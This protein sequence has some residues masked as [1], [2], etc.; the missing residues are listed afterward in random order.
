M[1]RFGEARDHADLAV[2]YVPASAHQMLATIGVATQQF[3]EAL[4][5]A[6]LAAAADP[7]LPLPTYVRG[8]I[9]YA[10][11]R[12][13]DA[14]PLFAA[15]HAAWSGRTIQVP[16]VRFY[17]GDTL[18]RFERYGEAERVFREELGLFPSS[19]RTRGALAMLYAATGREADVERAIDEMLTVSPGPATY[20]R[21]AELWQMFGRPDRAAAVR[22]ERRTRFGR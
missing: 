6:D 11:E 18:A 21:A 4:R 5:Q 2:P 22:N 16:D 20:D 3:D 17:L 10:E 7:G 19:V 14:L 13:A 9:A 1:G 12:Y 8:L 15:A